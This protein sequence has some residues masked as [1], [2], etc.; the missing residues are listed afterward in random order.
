MLLLTE[1]LPTPSIPSHI[2]TS[3]SRLLFY[4]VLQ[5]YSFPKPTS[6]ASVFDLV[7]G[8]GYTL[9]LLSLLT[10]VTY[11][12][13]QGG[14]GSSLASSPGVHTFRLSVKTLHIILMLNTVCAKGQGEA[15]AYK[16]IDKIIRTLIYHCLPLPGS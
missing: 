9:N 11:P 12:A 10:C 1:F 2:L 13:S 16:R 6:G 14:S 8:T 7:S 5:E 3:L 4:F 15:C